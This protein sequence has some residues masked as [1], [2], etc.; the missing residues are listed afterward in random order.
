MPSYWDKPPYS[1]G[2]VC[3]FSLNHVKQQGLSDPEGVSPS[4]FSSGSEPKHPNRAASLLLPGEEPR[5]FLPCFQGHRWLRFRGF[6]FSRALPILKPEDHRALASP[7]VFVEQRMRTESQAERGFISP[8]SQTAQWRALANPPKK[9]LDSTL[10][11]LCLLPFKLPS[12]P[13]R[14][15]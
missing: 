15:S 2:T 7:G 3:W 6:C 14:K 10:K 13:G 5:A 4:S 1:L 9:N 11:G 8:T 12:L